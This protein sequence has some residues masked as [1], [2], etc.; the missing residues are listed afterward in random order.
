LLHLGNNVLS[1][2]NLAGCVASTAK[3][4]VNTPSGINF[5][6]PLHSIFNFQ[7]VA[8][9]TQAVTISNAK[10]YNKTDGQISVTMSGMFFI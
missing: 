4:R 3:A 2:T 1:V 6:T 10:C 7:F 5:T 9:M 8:A